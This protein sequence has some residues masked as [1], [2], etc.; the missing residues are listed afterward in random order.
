MKKKTKPFSL[1]KRGDTWYA[2]LW[3]EDAG[4]YTGAKSTGESDRD[5]AA[6]RAAEMI[7]DGQLKARELDPLFIDSLLEYWKTK[8]GLTPYYQRSTIKAIENTVAIYPELQKLRLTQIRFFHINRFADH[9]EAQGRPPSV[10]NR[11]LQS[12]RS[13]LVYAYSR[14]YIPQN[15]ADG[16]KIEKKKETKRKR[17]ELRPAEIM[18]LAALE[19]PDHRMKVA[20]LLGCFAGLRRGEIRALRW[21]D[22]DFQTNYIYVRRNYTD[23]KDEKG[24][25][26]YFPP[27]ADSSRSFPY[28]VFPELRAALLKQWE[29]TPFKS[30]DDLVLPNVWGTNQQNHTDASSHLPLPD[31]A[32]KRNFGKML[33]A[34]GIPESEQG[35]RALSFHSTRHAFTSFVDMSGS[36][37]TAMA[38]TGHSTREML[39][40]YSHANTEA[41]I[42]HL[43]TANEFLNKFRKASGK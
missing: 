21:K 38:L 18:R 3:D 25:P 19:W 14:G 41:T 1:Y 7:K 31:T 29:E 24:N 8:K 17:G 34:I 9:L 4:T 26:V 2:R 42:E 22:I 35:E 43:Q 20:V 39:E 27:K 11:I 12:I 13:F 32:I 40:N 15:I 28:M 16:K 23:I 37:K 10:I 6:V 5:R 30:D 33:E 36:S